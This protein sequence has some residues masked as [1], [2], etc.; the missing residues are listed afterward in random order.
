VTHTERYGVAVLAPLASNFLMPN[1]AFLLWA[2]LAALVFAVL[3]L[4]PLVETI[5]R[6]QWGY[7]LGVVVFGPIG[8]L[9]RLVSG[10]RATAVR[11]SEPSQSR[12]T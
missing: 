9:L 10:R 1:A 3:V 4:W 8:G 6:R 12:A 11:L 2:F 5:V 7:T